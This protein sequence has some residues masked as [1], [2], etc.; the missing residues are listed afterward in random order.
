MMGCNPVPP[1][2]RTLA[3]PGGGWVAGAAVV[4][5]KPRAPIVSGSA[6]VHAS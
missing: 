6:P 4:R 1:I 5:Q 2:G 3:R